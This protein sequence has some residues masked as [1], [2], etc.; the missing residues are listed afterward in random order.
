M[1]KLNIAGNVTVSLKDWNELIQSN[2]YMERRLKNFQLA[3][4]QIKILLASLGEERV[5][6]DAIKAFNEQSKVMRIINADGEITIH[7]L[8]EAKEDSSSE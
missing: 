3:I 2:D 6:W 5:V 8:H 7:I 4:A 1:A